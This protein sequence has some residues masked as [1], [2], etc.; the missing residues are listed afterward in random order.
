MMLKTYF[1]MALLF[2]GIAWFS[3]TSMQH[4]VDQRQ[5]IASQYK[6]G[7]QQMTAY[8]K[9][10]GAL[11][12]KALRAGGSKQQFCGCVVQ[13]GL[14]DLRT[15]EADAVLGWMKD[16]MPRDAMVTGEQE[17]VLMAAISCSEQ[18]RRKWTSVAELQSWC[19]EKDERRGLSQCKLKL[20]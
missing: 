14:S 20:K 17:R 8:D 4:R 16:S 1:A 19:A 11:E 12:N 5:A 15:V 2:C 7:G 10:I 18:T 6:L 3:T 9:C 13:G